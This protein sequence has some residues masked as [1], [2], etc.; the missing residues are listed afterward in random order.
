MTDL[1]LLSILEAEANYSFK[2]VTK[3]DYS[4]NEAQYVYDDVNNF[5]IGLRLPRRSFCIP[6]AVYSLKHLKE[7]DLSL[8]KVKSLSESLVNLVNLEKLNLYNTEIKE[9]P[10]CIGNLKELKSINLAQTPIEILPDSICK[11]KNLEKLTLWGTHIRCLPKNIGKLSKLKSLDLSECRLR[12]LPE[13]IVNLNI[14]FNDSERF[15]CI[16][17]TKLSIDDKAI[18]SKV[19]I[20]KNALKEHFESEKYKNHSLDFESKI[21]LLGN[22]ASGK[23]S[24][25]HALLNNFFNPTQPKTEGISVSKW[26]VDDNNESGC[27]HIWDM[28]GQETYHPIYSLFLSKCDLYIVVLNGRSDEKPDLWLDFIQLYAPSSPVIIVINRIDESPKSEIDRN[29]YIKKYQ[30]L[31][32]VDIVKCSCKDYDKSS[33]NIQE[34][35][36]IIL[37]TLSDYR[38]KL[39]CYYNWR[40]FR[41]SLSKCEDK[42]LTFTE[43]NKFWKQCNITDI[44]EQ[45]LIIHN[46][47]NYGLFI[48]Q[49]NSSRYIIDL[50]WFSIAISRLYTYFE[51][52]KLDPIINKTALYRYLYEIDTSCDSTVVDEL[53][54]VLCECKLCYS[55]KKHIIVPHILNLYIEEGTHSLYHQ[56]YIIKYDVSSKFIFQFLL[57]HLLEY[58]LDD[59]HIWKNAIEL[60]YNN[61]VI[62]I[63]QTGKDIIIHFRECTTNTYDCINFLIANILQIHKDFIPFDLPFEVLIPYE[64]TEK[65]TNI[66][67]KQI[68]N[69]GGQVIFAKDN[70]TVTATNIYNETKLN[71]LQ[72]LFDE[73]KIARNTLNE[74]ERQKADDSIQIIEDEIE[75]KKP[76]KSYLNTALTVLKGIKGSAEFIAAVT[77]IAQFIEMI[78]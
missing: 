12:S 16:K 46:C 78:L 49:T 33:G 32:I 17:T 29:Y 38:L 44:A 72:D 40:C 3:L 42:Y 22:G 56:T 66:I 36:K 20:G 67:M 62:L 63:E 64:N 70:T 69:T 51:K 10:Q 5:V 15:D 37:S 50:E 1:D 53:I 11:L 47:C 26:I 7:L 27:I 18:L 68:I 2:L 35:R 39:L 57:I 30:K 13:S 28:G 34:L 48:K 65:E 23:T 58:R 24:L 45:D 4:D 41:K 77:S 61:T 74:E 59:N 6:E 73:L 14:D 25:M 71:E 8:V 55:S 9:L 31:R 76:R 60:R 52:H 54:E 43:L 75:S 19:K 21:V